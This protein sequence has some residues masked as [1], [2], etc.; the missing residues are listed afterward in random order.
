MPDVSQVSDFSAAISG[1]IGAALLIVA[2]FA[3]RQARRWFTEVIADVKVTRNQTTNDHK[4]NMRD[5]ITKAL[6]TIHAVAASV[7]KLDGKVCAMHEDLRESR[8][9]V[10]FNTEYIRDVDKRLN[11]HQRKTEQGGSGE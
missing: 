4:T 5:D 1:F 6:A 7:E 11:E 10:R 3:Y 9:D 8:R 2:G